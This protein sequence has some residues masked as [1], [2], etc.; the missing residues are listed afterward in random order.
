MPYQTVLVATNTAQ[1]YN[2]DKVVA[3]SG[4]YSND[5]GN[6]NDRQYNQ[7]LK[8][9]KYSCV[10]LSFSLSCTTSIYLMLFYFLATH[11]LYD[12]QKHPC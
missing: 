11:G 8:I 9:L 7:T 2:D 6:I 5:N 1:L 10:S 4:I 12:E 3:P